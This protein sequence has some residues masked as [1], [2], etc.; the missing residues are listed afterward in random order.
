MHAHGAI[1]LKIL[2]S[3]MLQR[4]GSG[5]PP[6]RIDCLKQQFEAGKIDRLVLSLILYLLFSVLP[7]GK[8]DTLALPPS[9][10]RYQLVRRSIPGSESGMII[11]SRT[12]PDT[13]RTVVFRV[14][15]PDSTATANEDPVDTAEWSREDTERGIFDQM[16]WE[17]KVRRAYV[18]W[19]SDDSGEERSDDD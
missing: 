1:N 5:R 13:D 3:Q 12:L 9:Y 7:I 18:D 16:E 6:K 2:V 17:R 14:A 8:I 19:V 11:G 15:F 4:K 10:Y